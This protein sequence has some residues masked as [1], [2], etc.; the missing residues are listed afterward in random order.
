MKATLLDWIIVGIFTFGLISVGYITRRFTKGVADFT[1]AG[2]KLRVWLGLSATSAE[3]IAIASIVTIAQQGYL[4]GFAYVWLITFTLLI[5]V[6]LIGIYGFGIKRYRATGVQTLP[7]YYE[8]RYSRGVRIL[9]GIAIV[10]GGILNMAIFPI[11]AAQFFTA[12][13]GLPDTL[14]IASIVLKTTTIVMIFIIGLALFFVLTGGFV[15]V[16]VTNYI[17]AIIMSVAIF[18]VTYLAIDHISPGNPTASLKHIQD[19]L[20]T[21]VGEGAF[22]PLAQGGYG[23]VWILFFIA[24]N[25]Y[26]TLAFPPSLMMTSGA[27]S[28]ETARKMYLIRVVINNGRLLCLLLWGV[29]ALAV[30]GTNMPAGIDA[31]S[32]QRT[33]AP[34]YLNMITPPIIIGITLAGLLFAEIG[35]TSGYILSW[36]S[37][38]VNDVICSMRKRPFTSK[39]HILL[40]RLTFIGV[41]V[42]LFLWG[43]YYKPTES[44]LTYV[45]LTGA[46][47]T[48]AGIIS[49]YGLYWKRTST[50]AAYLTLI[51][52]MVV[53][54]A[55]ILLKQNW[56]SVSF[57]KAWRPS[58]PLKGEESGLL[59]IVLSMVVIHIVS[60]FSKEKSQF[61][62]YGQRMR[63]IENRDKAITACVQKCP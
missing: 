14:V 56:D 62:D 49:F 52:C 53:P 21:A 54:L 36:C 61:V 2:R 4:H 39:Q 9:A 57:L 22:N 41:A 18:A 46:I 20:L 44:V 23:I 15:T 48:G 30:M 51:I 37:I 40:L 19:S 45:Y 10:V 13:L 47:F 50:L 38:I 58:Y 7:Q 11:I 43:L 55:D 5:C 8:M 28:P 27:E 31:E 12:F 6:P 35:T 32:Y 25:I 33:L 16:V 29:A 3:G 42:F 26:G 1:V 17:Q 59:A 60:Y 63:E 34:R 24:S